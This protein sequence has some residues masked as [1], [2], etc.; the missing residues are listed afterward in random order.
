[1]CRLIRTMVLNTDMMY[2]SHQ[3]PSFLRSQRAA[4]FRASAS[5]DHVRAP[6]AAVGSGLRNVLTNSSGGPVPERTASRI[7]S[8]SGPFRVPSNLPGACTQSGTSPARQAKS[9]TPGLHSCLAEVHHVH[10]RC[11][12]ILI[13]E[14][15]LM[16]AV[17]IY[18]FATE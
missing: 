8:N 11:K 15:S 5:A 10:R 2:H 7:L 16:D 4:R 6:V 17:L 13:F 1:M 9:S 12:Y 18:N 3:V 14:L